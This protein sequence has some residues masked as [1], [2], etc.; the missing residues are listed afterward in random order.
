MSTEH[1]ISFNC[2]E[3]KGLLETNNSQAGDDIECQHCHV[4]VSVP[5]IPS[6]PLSRP[7]V[8][9]IR[10]MRA[11]PMTFPYF[12]QLIQFAAL[13]LVLAIMVMLFMSVGLAAQ[14]C[15]VFDGLILDAHKQMKAGTSVEKS[16]Q[17]ISIGLYLI[18]RTPFWI[19]KLP[20]SVLGSLWSAYREKS[21]P[22]VLSLLVL[23][24]LLAAYNWKEVFQFWNVISPLI[25]QIAEKLIS[26]F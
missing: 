8:T 1:T 4:A 21:F 6:N 24:L 10:Q 5:R 19:I 15:R 14:V 22:V 13:T 25:Y 2:P 17:A 23:T 20:F 26:I 9:I 7:I 16:A 11:I 3:C 12:P 18:L